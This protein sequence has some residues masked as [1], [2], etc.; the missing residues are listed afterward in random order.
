[1]FKEINLEQGTQAWHEWRRVHITASDIPVLFDASP[2]KK[3][4]QL[5]EEKLGI[6]E[7]SPKGKEFLFRK[8]QEA[9]RSARSFL[10]DECGYELKPMVVESL[11]HPF[12]GAS[13]DAMNKENYKMFE[14]KYIGT[15]AIMDMP[16]KIKAHHILQMQAQMAVTQFDHCIYFA[17]DGKREARRVFER[18]DNLIEEIFSKAKDFMNE[19]RRF[20]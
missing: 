16:E 5:F 9:E 8:G 15:K 7:D 3:I 19:V 11:E 13:L 17:T 18:N 14:I 20:Q 6:A 4:K 2:Y 12:L 1:M 10:Q